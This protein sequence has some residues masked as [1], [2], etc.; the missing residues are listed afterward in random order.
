MENGW[1]SELLNFVEIHPG[2]VIALAFVLALLESLAV[3]GLLIPGIVLLF[4][5]GAAIGD[6]GGLFVLCWAAAA[7][8]GF[9]GD[10]VSFWVGRRF[11]VWVPQIWP[12]SRRPD[13]LAASQSLCERRGGLGVFLGRFIGPLRAFVPMVAGSMRL[14]PRTFVLWAVPACILWAPLY[15][16]P[17]MLFGASL[18][19]AAEFA[20]R[21]VV[22]L[23]IVV[24]G[25]WFA[26]WV[27]RVV[28]GFTARRSGWWLRSMIHWSRRHPRLG[29]L[30]GPLL[31][32]GGREVL[33]VALLGLM[34][35]LAMSALLGLLLWVPF[36]DTAW[37]VERQVSGWAASLRNH[38]ADPLFAALSLIGDVKVMAWLAGAMAVLLFGLGRSAAALHWLAATAGA[39]L[40]GLV[41]NALMGRM[42]AGPEFMPSLG[43]V[44]YLAFLLVVAVFGFFAVMLAKDLSARHRK[45]PYL[46]TAV[47]MA[48]I[49]L[50]HF[51]L[52][53]ATPTGL[54]TAL[55]LGLT[56]VALVGI[57]YRQRASKR[58]HPALFALTFAFLVAGFSVVEIE[59]ELGYRLQTSRL[60]QPQ[61]QLLLEEWPRSGWQALPDRLSR[62]GRFERSRFDLQL[63]GD[64]HDVEQALTDRGWINLTD[65]A[66]GWL[67]ELLPDD[68]EGAPAAHRSKDFAGRP[69][70][71]ILRWEG[72][73]SNVV[74]ARF[75]S[76]G[77]R[78]VPGGQPIW[79]GQI[80]TLQP[81]RFLG[82]FRRWREVETAGE[83]ALDRL[84]RALEDRV[85]RYR[86]SRPALY[87]WVSDSVASDSTIPSSASSR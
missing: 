4:V 22:V 85:V 48:L 3:V 38:L 26:V 14:P 53:R 76:S 45:W 2:W 37:D 51:Y 6:D 10:G 55:A 9:A 34:L 16:L 17:G 67:H 47:M 59:R 86:Q 63:A 81:G 52:G 35:L 24:L 75:W 27:T 44:P 72:P 25:L 58:R 7:A 78:L 20:G 42:M 82:V 8:G 66:R 77:A 19:L 87:R 68:P 54:L 64:L 50:A 49:G 84:D 39:W 13:L 21:L 60:A 69:D 29:R 74:V 11:S 80:R 31:E 30:L 41:L 12:L 36:M 56:W 28:Y 23:L 33:S 43:E 57:G 65:S 1:L 15:L 32:P 79:L 62:I 46:V 5:V 61:K 73:G 70:Q 83:E 40:L 71:L 18:E